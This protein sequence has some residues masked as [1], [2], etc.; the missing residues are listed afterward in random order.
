MAVHKCYVDY[1]TLTPV[2]PGRRRAALVL[3]QRWAASPASD[4]RG[5]HRRHP[6]LVLLQQRHECRRLRRVGQPPLPAEQVLVVGARPADSLAGVVDQDVQA[7]ELGGD[8]LANN[9]DCNPTSWP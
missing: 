7:V 5:V 3:E 9:V 1:S 8:V 4:R 6:P 2:G